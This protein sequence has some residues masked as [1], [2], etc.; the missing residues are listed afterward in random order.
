MRSENVQYCSC[1][2][3]QNKPQESCVRMDFILLDLELGGPPSTSTMGLS[4]SL[5]V[6]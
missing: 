2:F 6:D 3:L 5:S 1:G 4:N